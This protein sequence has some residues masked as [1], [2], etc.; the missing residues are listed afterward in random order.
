MEAPE[1]RRAGGERDVDAVG[2]QALQRRAL[3]ERLS[4]GQALLQQPLHLVAGGAHGAAHFGREGG[5]VAQHPR[6]LAAAPQVGDA[7]ALQGRA[8]LGDVQLL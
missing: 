6:D 2:R 4:L 5:Q 8:V 1:L 7:P 3:Q